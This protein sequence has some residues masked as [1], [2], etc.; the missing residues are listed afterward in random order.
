MEERT[1]VF[2][3]K[4]ERVARPRLSAQEARRVRINLLRVVGLAALL[5]FLM[6]GI[7]VVGGQ[8]VASLSS[9][10]DNG[11]WPFL[12]CMAVSVGQAVARGEPAGAGLFALVTSPVAFV[13][14]KVIQKGMSS[15]VNH[16]STGALVDGSL[17]MEAGLRGVEY[18]VLAAVLAWLT[19]KHWA[20]ALA[21][22]AVGAAI[23]VVFGL[24]IAIF[25]PP[26]SLLGWIVEEIVFPTGCS[27]V[28][29]T[30]VTLAELLPD[31]EAP[32]EPA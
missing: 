2:T 29:F 24:V 3:M 27:L 10:L 12:I 16:T 17:V 32:P 8:E 14:A 4:N 9:L 6:E 22:L 15:L 11:L 28:I 21:H 30:S 19:R 7:L 23:G 1:E 18:A 13:G 26:G 25:L 20:G 5:G 31:D